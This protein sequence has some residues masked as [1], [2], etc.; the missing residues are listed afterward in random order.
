MR[1]G[2]ILSESD[3]NL[4]KLALNAVADLMLRKT[5]PT[6]N[7]CNDKGFHSSDNLLFFS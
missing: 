6:V 5:N 7:P 4:I 1:V 3:L 2:F